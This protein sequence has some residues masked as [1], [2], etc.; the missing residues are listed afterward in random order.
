MIEVDRSM[1]RDIFVS[2]YENLRLRLARQL[3]CDSLARET[4]HDM[5]VR[6]H[7]PGDLA[8]GQPRAYLLR[9]ALNI[10][11]DRRRSEGRFAHVSDVD[12][13]ALEVSDDAAD[14]A[15]QL[16]ARQ[17]LERLAAALMELSPRR[18][19]ILLASRVQG[20]TLWQIAAGLKVSQRL[21]EMELKAAVEHCAER[22]GRSVVRR[23]GPRPILPTAAGQGALAVAE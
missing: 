12:S 16:G 9:M 2:S 3:G 4:L 6:L 8:V 21:V 22:L 10:A 20:Q 14:S 5:F 11:S 19:Q 17:E 18:R 15:R 13:V 23:F 1:L 7:H